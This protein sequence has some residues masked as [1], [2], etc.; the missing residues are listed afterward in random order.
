MR[1]NARVTVFTVS[2]LLGENFWEAG[3]FLATF[4]NGA[5]ICKQG[6]QKLTDNCI[7]YIDINFFR[8]NN[9]VSIK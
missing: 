7:K 8:W 1:E 4:K 5:Y 9:Q 6:A 3:Q 2:E